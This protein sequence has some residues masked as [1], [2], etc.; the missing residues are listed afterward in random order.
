[1]NDQQQSRADAL[2]DAAA[3]AMYEK[4]SIAA[5]EFDSVETARVAFVRSI[6]AASP[7][8]QPAAAPSDNAH[9]LAALDMHRAEQKVPL[10]DVSP[11]SLDDLYSKA[12]PDSE[13]LKLVEHYGSALLKQRTDEATAILEQIQ[14]LATS[15]NETGAEGATWRAGVEAVAKMIEKKAADYLDEYGYVEHDTGAVSWGLGNHA[16]EKRD[17]HASLV[18]LAEEV[19]AMAPAMVAAS[20]AD[21]RATCTHQWTWADGKCADCGASTH[22]PTPTAGMTLGERIVHVGGRVTDGG[23]VEFG[24]AMALDALV[25]HVLRDAR[26]AASPA[27]EWPTHDEAIGIYRWIRAQAHR[28]PIGYIEADELEKLGSPEFADAPE[29]HVRLWHPYNPP[30]RAL[31]PVYSDPQPA[32]A[33][34][35]AEAREPAAWVTPEGDRALTQ[36]QKQ[37]M[38]RDGG[39]S[40]SSVRPYSIPCYAGS[41]P[42]GA[43]EARLT[44][45]QKATI[46]W[47]IRAAVEAGYTADADVLRA[48]LNGAD[49]A[50]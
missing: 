10:S 39:A 19:R 50:R 8:E 29:N 33:D 1:M 18:E 4:A 38:L 13:I 27:A 42:A 7:V 24:S 46:N 47:A 17:Y 16:D 23:I 37:G 43:G 34:A 21:E 12:E 5:S 31:I 26:A 41:A 48:L 3:L 15:A 35:P 32:Q 6:L 14:T 11:T 9:L 49:H 25:Q 36:M 30:S 45:E 44:D 2:T 20:P 40:A 22:G 28:N